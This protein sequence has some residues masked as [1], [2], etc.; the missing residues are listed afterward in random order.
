MREIGSSLGCASAEAS[1]E[2]CREEYSANMVV[3]RPDEAVQ[4]LWAALPVCQR[5]LSALL[6][7]A[8]PRQVP[9]CHP[10]KMRASE[11]EEWARG[12]SP[13]EWA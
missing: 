3:W 12:V 6:H 2:I 8:L 4:R 13:S 9:R 1:Y 11:P 7:P 10:T 5:T